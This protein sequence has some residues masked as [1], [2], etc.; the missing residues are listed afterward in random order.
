MKTG[1]VLF[2]TMAGLSVGVISSILF[3]TEKGSTIRKQITDNGSDYVDKLKSRFDGSID[4]LTDK[5][6]S[7][8]KDTEGLVKRK[9]KYDNKNKM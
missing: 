1:K 6:K 5:F 3:P 9:A 2:G 8:K 7:T 4:A